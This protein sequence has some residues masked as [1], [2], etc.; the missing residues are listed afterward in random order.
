MKIGDPISFLDWLADRRERRLEAHLAAKSSETSASTSA[1][2]TPACSITAAAATE[3]SPVLSPEP[4][5]PAP[6]KCSVVFA[7]LP[8][9]QHPGPHHYHH[10][11]NNDNDNR[12]D[13]NDERLRLRTAG[14]R[15]PLLLGGFGSTTSSSHEDS[16]LSAES[17]STPSTLEERRVSEGRSWASLG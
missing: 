16:P 10:D 4:A 7:H 11:H 12:H 9:R 3:S 8:D 2:A 17:V 1:S 15:A 13:S 6:R 5:P 14:L